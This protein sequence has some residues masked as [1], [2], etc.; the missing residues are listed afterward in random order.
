M[1]VTK[2][3]KHVNMIQGLAQPRFSMEKL[4]KPGRPEL[5]SRKKSTPSS[6]LFVL[7]PLLIKALMSLQ[8]PDLICDAGAV[9]TILRFSPRH[10][11]AIC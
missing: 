11:A 6:V 8:M 4:T 1:T 9:T 7:Q 3:S 10:N 2:S 5:I